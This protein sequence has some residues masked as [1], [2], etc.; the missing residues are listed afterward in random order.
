[1]NNQKLNKKNPRRHN[2]LNSKIRKGEAEE[3]I[4]NKDNKIIS[5]MDLKRRKVI[6]RTI[7][8]KID[9][10]EI[11]DRDGINSSTGT[12]IIE[13]ENTIEENE[14]IEEV[15]A[16]IMEETIEVPEII[17]AEEI[18]EVAEAA[19]MGEMI[20]YF[21]AI[22]M[23]E[24]KITIMEIKDTTMETTEII[25]MDMQEGVGEEAETMVRI[26]K[27]WGIEEIDR[28]TIIMPTLVTIIEAET[29]ISTLIETIMIEEIT[30]MANI[31]LT[32]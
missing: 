32:I 26:I 5:M 18:T 13:E 7:K 15:E 31:K 23:I 4:E 28:E 14:E 20:E 24:V 11:G 27:I 21:K 25:K 8:D 10:G 6:S 1:M 16:I 17:E 29:N 9:M 3:E 30:T 22:K 2:K 12:T 19:E